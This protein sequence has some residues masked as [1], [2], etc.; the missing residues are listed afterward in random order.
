MENPKKRAQSKAQLRNLA[1]Y[2][3]LTDEEFEELWSKRDTNL[4]T[5]DDFEDRI[6]KKIE[7]FSQD[8]DIED[9][10]IND[11]EAL[12]AFVQSVIALED[13]EKIIFEIRTV[14]G[15]TAGN[16]QIIERIS[17][18]MSDLRRDISRAQDDL[19][20]SRKRRK[21]DRESSVVSY[22][23]DLKEKARQFYESKSSYIFCP[24][25]NMLIGTVWA[26]Y[27]DADNK[28][29]L[30]CRRDL[31][32]GKI[33]EGKAVVTTKE[34]TSQKGTNKPSITPDSLL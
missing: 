26:L 32:D 2:R 13:Y 4:S 22:I 12:R 10:K 7:E 3:E 5:S 9:L 27:P 29:T 28:I 17:K 18:V 16:I 33:C 30:K 8:Y 19:N 21:S 24:E 11:R 34:L 31:G 1:Q 20:I 15:V 25:C 14:S 23:A 6:Q